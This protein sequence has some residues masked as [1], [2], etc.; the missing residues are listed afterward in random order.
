MTTGPDC[1]IIE[2]ANPELE[3]RDFLKGRLEEQFTEVLR[4]W[5]VQGIGLSHSENFKIAVL[6]V[7][8]LLS[9]VHNKTENQWIN[10]KQIHESMTPLWKTFFHNHIHNIFPRE[11][12][13]LLNMYAGNIHELRREEARIL[14][15]ETTHTIQVCK[16]EL[17]NHKK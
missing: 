1:E 17:K 15:N 5:E 3:R 16:Q 9:F 4:V 13:Q 8:N 12:K 7:G 14:R 11:F 2:I 6:E 10:F